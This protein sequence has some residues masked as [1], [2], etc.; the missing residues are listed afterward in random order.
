MHFVT[1]M[2]ML[3][4]GQDG[5]CWVLSTPKQSLGSFW[6]TVALMFGLPTVVEQNP[7]ENIPPSPQK[8]RFASV[9]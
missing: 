5:F 9:A 6:Q 8:T 2:N 1:K 3:L 4:I 7:V